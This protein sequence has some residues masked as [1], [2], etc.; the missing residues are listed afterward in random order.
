MGWLQ[1]FIEDPVGTTKEAF[2]D[3]GDA[4]GDV[5]EWVDE[6]IITPIKEDPIRFIVIAAAYSYGIPGLDFAPAYSAAATGIASGAYSLAQAS[7]LKILLKTV[8]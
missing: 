2:D 5:A 4:L 8:L 6:K 1:D 3:V 7:L